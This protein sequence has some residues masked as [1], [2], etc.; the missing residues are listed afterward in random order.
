MARTPR[1]RPTTLPS[2]ASAAAG[3]GEP[4]RIRDNSARRAAAPPTIARPAVPE[5]KRH[6]LAFLARLQ[7]R[8]LGDIVAELRKVTWP[9]F[10]ETRY[11][12]IVVGIVATAVGLALGGIDL[13]FGWIVEKLFFS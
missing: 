2:A 5:R 13:V 4:R 9:T 3:S 8:F 7:P 11:L 12:T 10:A 1:R 6:P